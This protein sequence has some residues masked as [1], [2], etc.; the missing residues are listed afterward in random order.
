MFKHYKPSSE[1]SLIF[2]IHNEMYITIELLLCSAS[3]VQHVHPTI[4]HIY[5]ITVIHYCCMQTHN[6][7]SALPL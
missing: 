3:Y 1:E 6:H 5:L 2:L 4:E 7:V